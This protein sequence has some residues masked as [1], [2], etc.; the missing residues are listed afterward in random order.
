MNG[1]FKVDA[2]LSGEPGPEYLLL[3]MNDPRIIDKVVAGRQNIG[4]CQPLFNGFAVGETVI[5]HLK[6][7]QTGAYQP[8]L[9]GVSYHTFPN[10]RAAVDVWIEN[11]GSQQTTRFSFSKTQLID[12]I[13]SHTGTSAQP[14]R[15]DKPYPFKAPIYLETATGWRY[16]LPVDHTAPQPISAEEAF[17]LRRDQSGCTFPPCMVYSP[18]GLNLIHLIPPNDTSE[19][20]PGD[21]T[22]LAYYVEG[23]RV[24]VSPTSEWLA[25][26]RFN[27]IEI[28]ALFYGRLGI[29]SSGAPDLIQSIAVDPTSF[30][31]SAAWSQDGRTLAYSD[32]MGLWLWDVTLRSSLP[33]LVVLNVGDSPQARYF[34]PGGHFLA[35][36]AGAI[37]YT[38]NLSNGERYPDGLVSPDDRL[39]LVFDTAN[40]EISHFVVQSLVPMWGRRESSSFII[41]QQVEWYDED[42]FIHSGCGRGYYRNEIAY[43]DEPFCTTYQMYVGSSMIGIVRSWGTA[44]TDYGGPF[45]YDRQNDAMLRV[46]GPQQI[47]VDQEELD[48]SGMIDGEITRASWLPSLFYHDGHL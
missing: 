33:R 46:V 25:L 21:D 24:Q 2:Y 4:E 43:V 35:V 47:A 6:H 31:L 13:T 44:D 7:N 15:Y 9:F 34:S 40:A 22:T 20:V 30:S 19:R 36:T 16:L 1:V 12:Y 3:E 18:D 29:T 8:A 48:L 17:H 42:E 5:V 11:T 39:L 23:D 45:D 28:Y 27:R 37:G 10:P 14:P 38:L 26:W 41:S 32:L